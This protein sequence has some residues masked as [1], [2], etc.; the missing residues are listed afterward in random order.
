MKLAELREANVTRQREWDPGNTI[1]LEYRGNELAGETGEACNV[2]KKLARER[3]GL[4]GSRAT[5]AQLAEELADIV[6]CVDLIAMQLNIDLGEAVRVKFNAT[7]KRYGLET[8]IRPTKQVERLTLGK[9]LWV[10]EDAT[11]GTPGHE[12][13]EGAW[14]RLFGEDFD[15][16]SAIEFEDGGDT[17]LYRM[18]NG[19]IACSSYRGNS[20]I[21]AAA[22]GPPEGMQER[23]DWQ[24]P[25]ASRRA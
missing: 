3:L 17:T 19:A 18:P 9:R 22:D 10:E 25:H 14:R 1:T 23:N 6:I 20:A 24:S 4:R 8:C 12:G 2:I 15:S 16:R 7:S 5:P 21:Y 11:P 13:I